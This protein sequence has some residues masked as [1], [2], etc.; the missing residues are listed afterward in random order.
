M[1][2]TA[3][4]LETVLKV[5]SK[6]ERKAAEETIAKLRA[7]FEDRLA[8]RIEKDI[9]KQKAKSDF[10]KK[11]EGIRAEIKKLQDRRK[12]DAQTIKSLRQQ[13]RD[14]RAEAKAE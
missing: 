7:T 12:E 11:V 2:K 1:T 4:N 14:A 10:E 5:L 6:D 8:N 9:E 3:S 13:I